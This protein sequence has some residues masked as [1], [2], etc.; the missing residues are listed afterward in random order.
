MVVTT[1]VVAVGLLAG[2]LL[3]IVAL[4][5]AL[6]SGLD[7]AGRARAGE[8]ATLVDQDRLP[9]SLPAGTGLVQVVDAQQRVRAAT[10]GAD[11][12]VPMLEGADLAAVGRGD[13]RELSAARLGQD[14][15]LRVVGR[16]AG[17]PDD[18][19]TVLVASSLTQV[20]DSTRVVRRGLLIGGP[21]LLALVAGLAWLLTGSVLRP[22]A[23]LRAGA[24][25]ITGTAQITGSGERRRLPVPAAQDELHRLA[26]T[27]NDMI[28][29]LEAA[30]AAQRAFVADAAHELRSPLAS[31]RTQLEVL[32]A[33]PGPDWPE[34]A[35]DVL[36]DIERLA[37]LVDD[38]LLLARADATA[39]ASTATADLTAVAAREVE[40]PRSRALA[41][42]L[43][44]DRQQVV[45]GD[46]ARLGRVVSNLLDNAVR[47][48]RSSV[49]VQVRAEG[50][51]VLLTVD[52]DG[53][54]IAAAD[55]DRVF[56]R[57]TRLDEARGR[58]AGG[59]GLGLAIVRELVR[60]LGGRIELTDAPEQAALGGQ[61]ASSAGLRAVVRLPAVRE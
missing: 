6:I 38:L 22:V 26:T 44:A 60:G 20:E 57:F 55:R 15:S 4:R 29:R 25:Q 21:L 42:R 35:A 41:V 30:S 27:L 46:A 47:H 33:H 37:R 12:L 2:S 24:A 7:D 32:L 8:V 56:E 43:V 9:G 49:V 19:L 17:P 48:A 52:D 51:E 1:A 5:T 45:R 53:P 40:R 10:P 34:V 59:S 31:A 39:E 50:A 23:A 16:P 54:G 14:G 3:V 13:T 36:I 28:D 61:S 18:P 58:D 11:R